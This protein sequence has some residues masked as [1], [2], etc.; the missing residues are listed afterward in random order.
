M[1]VKQVGSSGRS[2]TDALVAGQ[3]WNGSNMTYSFPTT[4]VQ[5][6]GYPSDHPFTGFEPFNA[7]QQAAVRSLLS[8]ISTFTKLTFTELRAGDT[9]SAVLRFGMTDDIDDGVAAF[10]YLPSPSPTGGD[11]WYRNEGGHYDAPIAGNGAWRVIAHE[12]GHALGLAHPHAEEGGKPPMPDDRDIVAWTVMSYHGYP[13]DPWWWPQSYM[14]E[15]IA[16]L[17]FLYGANFAYNST[18]TV[19]R[20]SPTTGELSINGVGQGA[21]GRNLV[22]ETVWDGGGQDTYDFSNHLGTP[23]E[24]TGTGFIHGVTIDLR[25]GGWTRLLPA[26]TPTI[27]GD[28]PGNIANALQFGGDSRSLIEN[29]VGTSGDDTIHGNEA[30]NRLEGR[31]ARDVLYGHGGRDVLLGGLGHDELWGGAGDD[32]LI[33]GGD[34]DQ[35]DGGD[36]NDLLEAGNFSDYLGGGA[37]DDVLRAG[38]GDDDLNGGLG[39]NLLFGGTGLDTAV[40]SFEFVEAG[41]EV[42]A[43]GSVTV[44]GPGGSRDDLFDIEMLRFPGQSFAVHEVIDTPLPDFILIGRDGW[45]GSIGGLG[46]IFGTAGVQD[47]MFLDDA[48]KVDLDASFNS[49]GDVLRFTGDAAEFRGTIGGSR[50]ILEHA[51][52][53]AAISIPIGSAKTGL[54]FDDGLRNLFYDVSSG[55]VKIGSQTLPAST[56]TAAAEPAATYTIDPAAS[57]RLVLLTDAQVALAGQYEIIGSVMPD[58][59]SIAGAG[60]YVFDASFNRGLDRVELDHDRA[61]YTAHL[62]GSRVTLSGAGEELSLPVGGTPTMLDFDGDERALFYET[63]TGTVWLGSDRIDSANPLVIPASAVLP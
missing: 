47:I 24:N 58:E 21:P 36:G 11:S 29:A 9:S 10:A 4:T 40:F 50:L 57:A 55:T 44:L 33:G 7:G 41:F 3:I 15:D 20:W 13:T 27:S 37:G 38:G 46:T 19:Y 59:I 43:D 26:Q 28:V 34:S 45:R 62:K 30:A 16:A 63:T 52:G 18:D 2:Y 61:S 22:F 14:A 60:L 25:P 51:S 6:T 39:H 32:H 53:G 17:Q 12:I 42:A 1:D 48:G 31:D 5:F 54:H 23:H 56:I 35:M 8:S 49:G